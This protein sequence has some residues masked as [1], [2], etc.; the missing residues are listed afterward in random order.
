M[1]KK[2]T[3]LLIICLS[4]LD[5]HSVLAANTYSINLEESSSQYL[6]ISDA[7]QTGLDITGDLSIMAWLNFETLPV[8]DGITFALASKFEWDSRSWYIQF[9]K[10]SGANRIVFVHNDGSSNYSIYNNWTPPSAD[11]WIHFAFT[12]D[13][14]AGSYEIWKDGV[15]QG[16]ASGCGNSLNN[17]SY[18]FQIGSL[19]SGNIDFDGKIDE[20]GIYNTLLSEATIQA[21]YNSGN[22]TERS[23]SETGIQ[24]GWRFEDNLLDVSSN[25]NDLTNNNS[26]TYSADVPFAGTAEKRRIILID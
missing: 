22:G 4:F 1:K 26:A 3:I 21:D 24:G 17:S 8:N 25:D 20:F 2:I 15:S 10:D 18:P 13:A 19:M 9:R 16:T 11:T 6:S 7:A 14:S 23:G 12:Y 5:M